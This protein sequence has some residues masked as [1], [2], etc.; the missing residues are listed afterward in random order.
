M[1][2]VYFRTIISGKAIIEGTTDDDQSEVSELLNSTLNIDNI[3]DFMIVDI[4]I[5]K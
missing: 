5:T 1:K 3:P 2:T 4:Q